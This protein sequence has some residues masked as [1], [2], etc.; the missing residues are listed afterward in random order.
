MESRLELQLRALLGEDVNTPVPQ[1]RLEKLLDCIRFEETYPYEPIARIERYL[2]RLID[3]TV[4]IPATP[5]SRAEEILEAMIYEKNLTGFTSPSMYEELLLQ[6]KEHK[7][8]SSIVYSELT[9][10]TEELYIPNSVSAP[11]KDLKLYGKCTQQETPSF[12]T[13]QKIIPAGDERLT[14]TVKG[15]NGSRRLVHR[16]PNGIPNSLPEDSNFIDKDGTHWCCDEI[17]FERGK[18][19]RRVDRVVFDETSENIKMSFEQDSNNRVFCRYIFDK[20]FTTSLSSK[21]HA[22]LCNIGKSETDDSVNKA[23]SCFRGSK[24]LSYQPMEPFGDNNVVLNSDAEITNVDYKIASY[25]IVKGEGA[26][27]SDGY[28]QLIHG[29]TYTM[30]ICVTPPEKAE[31][32]RP[33]ISRGW[34][35]LLQLP[36]DGTSTKQILVGSFV[37]NYFEDMLPSVDYLH[38]VLDIYRLKNTTNIPN[39]PFTIHWIKIERGKK[40]L[41]LDEFKAALSENPL[42]CLSP[43]EPVESDLTDSELLQYKS[44]RTFVGSNTVTSSVP[45]VCK[46]AVPK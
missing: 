36:T 26:T 35:P 42:E 21:R 34:A 43:C 7:N 9:A 24:A 6:L 20:A 30:A 13:P 10:A 39:E 31:V 46:Y 41:S 12:D 45:F 16:S 1:S 19:I 23:S 22:V 18:F 4:E 5:E 27:T 28:G 14:V 25:R 3:E 44:L 15:T 11:I 29:E 2:L 17:D 32:I 33:H 37:A 40:C 38:S 8:I